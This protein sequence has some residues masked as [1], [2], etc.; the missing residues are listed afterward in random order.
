MEQKYVMINGEKVPIVRGIAEKK[1]R[2][3]GGVDVIVK[4]P[5]LSMI[6]KSQ[7]QQK[8]G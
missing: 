8:E 4:A 6:N 2:D 5:M 1:V 7:G 3:D